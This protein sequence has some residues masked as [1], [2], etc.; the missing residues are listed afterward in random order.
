[1]KR[2]A[3]S[4][5][6]SGMTPS[7]QKSVSLQAIAANAFAYELEEEDTGGRAHRCVKSLI[8]N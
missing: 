3:H 8:R 1:M 7:C 5:E 6:D 2:A 4:L